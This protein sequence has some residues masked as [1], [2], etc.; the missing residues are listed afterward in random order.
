MRTRVSGN[1]TDLLGIDVGG[2]T[3]R[4]ARVSAKGTIVTLRHAPT[5]PRGEPGA[6]TELL[7]RLS[8]E[9]DA[10][11]CRAV[12]LGVPG[13]RDASGRVL[14]RAVNLAAL[15][16]TDLAALVQRAV[17]ATPSIFA[18][19][20]AAA[21]AQW[22]AL[23]DAPPRFVYVSLGTGVG[24]C[25]LIDGVPRDA[26]GGGPGQLGHLIVDT[27]DDAPACGCG[28]VGCLEACV[29]GPVIARSGVTPRA[30]RQLAIGLLQLA[31]LWS[32][33]VI[34][35]GGGVIE[36][37]AD[38]LN[39]ARREFAEKAG[40]LVSPSLQIIAAPLKSDDAGVI[41]AALLATHASRAIRAG[42]P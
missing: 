11:G 1:A 2:T 20:T 42:S 38:L 34:A 41:G 17:R 31:H 26:A 5:P 12:G 10:A 9:V 25:A 13:R 19:V 4:V 22:R 6:L 39:A 29:A 23:D 8:R 16:G 15:E 37:H 30:A 40:S 32:P 3:T 35:V 28:A 21:F 18:D 36:H 14:E 33:A 7:A 27:A 24:G